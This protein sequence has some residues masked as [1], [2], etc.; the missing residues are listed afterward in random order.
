MWH[1]NPPSHAKP[2]LNLRAF[3]RSSK[4]KVLTGSGAFVTASRTGSLRTALP[5]C[6]ALP[7]FPPAT[8]RW[9]L[10]RCD[11]EGA[12]LGNGSWDS[13]ASASTHLRSQP[14]ILHSFCVI[15]EP[16]YIRFA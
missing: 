2:T 11:G 5:D 15:A 3:L 9:A 13:L 10:L 14:S 16:F 8:R 7:R 4:L 12:R 6:G 1:A